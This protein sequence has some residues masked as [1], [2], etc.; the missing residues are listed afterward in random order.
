M[1]RRH[2][3]IKARKQGFIS[4]QATKTAHL[5][6]VFGRI[7]KLRG[8]FGIFDRYFGTPGRVTS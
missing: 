6:M 5:S 1:W 4:G 2:G 3:A 8:K 7:V